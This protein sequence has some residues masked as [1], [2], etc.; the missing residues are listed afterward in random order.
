LLIKNHAIALNPVDWKV[1]ALGFIVKSYPA[2]LGVDVAG[3]VEDVG[4]NVTGFHKGDKVLGYTD[5]C[6]AQNP[7]HGSFREHTLLHAKSAFKIPPNLS[8]EQAATIPT[9]ALTA[10]DGFYYHLNLP[11]PSPTAK[12][13]TDPQ[14]NVLVLGGS[15]SV[16]SYAVQFSSKVFRTFATA[17]PHNHGLVAS[18]GASKLFNQQEHD[19]AKK[20]VAEGHVKIVFDCISSTDTMKLA[21]EVLAAS[22]GGVLL[23]VL[24]APEEIT[25]LIVGK[26]IKY[27]HVFTGNIYLPEGAK[28][29][30]WLAGYLS[31]ALESGSIV[32]NVVEIIGNNL[33]SIHPGLKRLEEGKVSGKKLVV[34]LQ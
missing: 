26:H 12:A 10:T 17:S 14:E 23:T 1:Y 18:L 13:T 28:Y 33:E 21:V 19:L 27:I 30:H 34:K 20:I 3:I 31:A 6:V 5:V 8:F 11:H 7:E 25:K 16:G 29:A 9:G 32:P 4:P 15:S 22:G 24:A 2:T